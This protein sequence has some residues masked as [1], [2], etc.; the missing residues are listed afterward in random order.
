MTKNSRQ[1]CRLLRIFDNKEPIFNSSFLIFNWAIDYSFTFL[2]QLRIG[3]KNEITDA[4]IQKIAACE[5]S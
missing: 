1:V 5:K 4:P 3:N 2:P